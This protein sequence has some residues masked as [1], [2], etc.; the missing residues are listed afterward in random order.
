MKIMKTIPSYIV[1]LMAALLGTACS[2]SFLD[3]EPMTS[4]LDQNFYKTA[5]DAE[6]ALVGC[7]D[8][9]QRTSSNGVWRF[10]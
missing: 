2:E 3:T 4:V 6:M 10:R 8:G 5:A 9:Y 1:A 7:Y